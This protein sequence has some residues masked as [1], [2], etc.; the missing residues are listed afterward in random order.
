MK[1]PVEEPGLLNAQSQYINMKSQNPT[2]FDIISD[3][4]SPYLILEDTEISLVHLMDLTVDCEWRLFGW[5]LW[6][7]HCGVKSPL[8]L[9]RVTLFSDLRALWI[10]GGYCI[11]FIHT[12][13]TWKAQ[14]SSWP[15]GTSES[16]R[17]GGISDSSQYRMLSLEDVS[18]D[19]DRM[20]SQLCESWCTVKDGND[21]TS[22]HLAEQPPQWQSLFLQPGV[23]SRRL[24]GRTKV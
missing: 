6:E 2:A 16:P 17:I 22:R 1:P 12:S 5:G 8:R 11:D 4:S 3:K 19:L 21:S 10:W 24:P 13:L 18:S 14:H 20:G 15:I 9:F 23:C 7:H